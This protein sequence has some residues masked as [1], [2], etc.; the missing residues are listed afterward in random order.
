MFTYAVHIP[1]IAPEMG[2]IM[3]VAYI[4]SD[5]DEAMQDWQEKYGIGP[6]VVTRD[7]TPLA[8]ARYR[9]KK[10]EKV[11]V[12]IAFAYHGDLQIELIELRQS[13][14]SMYK[15]ALDRN[16]R[17]LQHYGLCVENF[18]RAN[19]FAADNGFVP[20]LECGVKGLARMNYVEATDYSRNVFADNE[21]AY[22]KTPEGHGIVLEVIEDNAMTRPY[23]AGIKSIVEQ[24]PEGQLAQEFKLN[25]L[26][27]LSLL[28][29]E[30]GKLLVK[31]ILGK[32]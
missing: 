1:E 11:V 4:V 2:K 6:F 27:P 5:I 31:K 16:Q 9:G 10:S 25:D 18:E 15:E 13:V 29:P 21:K 12:S 30:L 28:L 20:I 14:P 22:M 7:A 8:N 23:F 26:M 17:D 3:Q 19:E 32:A 24:I